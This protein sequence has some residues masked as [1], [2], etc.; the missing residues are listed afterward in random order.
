MTELELL[1]AS[2]L[3]TVGGQRLSRRLR[4]SLLNTGRLHWKLLYLC[5]TKRPLQDNDFVGLSNLHLLGLLN[6]VV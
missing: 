3:L 1:L 5:R 6:F 4:G 2:H